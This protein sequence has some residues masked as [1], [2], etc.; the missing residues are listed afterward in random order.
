MDYICCSILQSKIDALAVNDD[1]HLNNETVLLKKSREANDI[2]QNYSNGIDFWS[3]TSYY[4]SKIG[5]VYTKMG[6]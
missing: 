1:R 5:F 4:Y 2:A 3:Q 6:G